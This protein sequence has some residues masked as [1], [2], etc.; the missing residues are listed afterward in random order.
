MAVTSSRR[1]ARAFEGRTPREHR[2][3]R[4]RILESEV[5]ALARE[6]VHRMGGVTDQRNPGRHRLRHA[7]LP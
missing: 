5:D 2:R 7:H 4:A 6:R 1:Y 3:E